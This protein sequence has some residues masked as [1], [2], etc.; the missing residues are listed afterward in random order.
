[1]SRFPPLRALVVFDAAMRSG[2]FSVAAD[3][4]CVTP[5]AVGQ[6]I[7]KLE[8]WLGIPLFIRQVRQ[9]QATEDARAYWQRIQPALAQ[10]ADA[11]HKFRDSR[12]MAV[13]LSMPPSFAAK[14]FTRRMARLLTQHPEIELHLNATTALVDFERESVDLS[15]RYFNGQ[16]PNLD[17]SLLFK[18][19][20][21]VYCSP[22]YA[23][24][25]NLDVPEDLGHATL[26]LTTIHPLWPQWLSQFSLLDERTIAAIPRIHFDQSMMAI[27]AAKLGQGVVMASPLLAAGELADGTL[28]EPF[29]HYLPL[30]NA[31]YVVHHSKLPLRPAAMLVKQWLID[32]ARQ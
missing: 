18:D 24:A 21:R 22:E 14:W 27:E 11:S 8:D 2:S 32:E 10:I 28:I 13:T 9:V 26:L 15:I 12:S 4:L 7:Q 1:M 31:Y 19:E 20:A 25:L 29:G 6:Q 30:S 3:E 16:A 5:G 23:K 17:A